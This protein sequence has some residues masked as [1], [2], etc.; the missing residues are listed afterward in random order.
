MLHSKWSHWSHSISLCEEE[1]KWSRSVKGAVC[2]GWTKYCSPNSKYWRGFF[3]R[4]IL[5]RLDVHTGCQINYTNRNEC[6]WRWIQLNVLYCPPT[7]NP[8]FRNTIGKLAVCRFHKPKHRSIFR[9]WMHISRRIT[10][11]STVFQINMYVNLACF[12]KIC[13]YIMIF[14]AS[15]ELKSYI[16]HL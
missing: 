3:T 12:L 1:R 16:Q 5:L 2:N 7:G 6:T 13:K 10:D 8:G 15:V 4:T 11:C 9:P 14:Y